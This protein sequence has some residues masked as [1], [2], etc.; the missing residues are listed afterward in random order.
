MQKKFL[1]S[2]PIYDKNS[3]ESGHRG[4]IPQQA[5]YDKSTASIKLSGEK[6]NTFPLRPRTRQT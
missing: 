4:Y 3:P 6:V 1:I 2:S 5:R